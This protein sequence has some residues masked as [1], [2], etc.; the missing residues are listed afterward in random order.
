M[1][2]DEVIKVN[3]FI[4]QYASDIPYCTIHWSMKQFINTLVRSNPIIIILRRHLDILLK[5]RSFNRIPKILKAVAKLGLQW[6]S[7]RIAR[8]LNAPIPTVTNP[9]HFRLVFLLDPQT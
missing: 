7:C 9:F 6:C 8:S 2:L 4:V 5:S 1:I 3:Y